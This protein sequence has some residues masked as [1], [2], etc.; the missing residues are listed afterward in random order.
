M[1][2][3]FHCSK[4]PNRTASFLCT[5][6]NCSDNLICLTCVQSHTNHHSS[7]FLILNDT[8]IDEESLFHIVKKNQ[9][10]IHDKL[11]EIIKYNEN[12]ISTKISEIESIF[13]ILIKETI[14]AIT[15]FKYEVISKF[16]KDYYQESKIDIDLLN[17]LHQNLNQV[18]LEQEEDLFNVMN[19]IQLLE[20]D[21]LPLASKEINEIQ[22]IDA[23]HMIW[24]TFKINPQFS[25]N[26][27]GDLPEYC[28]RSNFFGEFIKFSRD[29]S[30][31]Y[32]TSFEKPLHQLNNSLIV[33]SP[34]RLEADVPH[35]FNNIIIEDGGKLSIDPWDGIKGGHLIL[36]CK[37][38]QIKPYGMIDVSNLGYLGGIPCDNTRPNVAYA[39]ES[40]EKK[41]KKTKQINNGGGG[42]GSQNN[43]YGSCGGGGGGY[44]TAGD[45]S[46][47]NIYDN[48]IKEGGAGGE[49]YGDD[50]MS[51]IYMGSGGG[52]G[53]PYHNG[54]IKAKG[55]NGGGIVIIIAEEFKNEGKV[56]ANG[57]DGEDAIEKSSGSGGGGGSG[58]SIYIVTDKI[59]EKGILSVIG[60]KG[61][62][63][64]KA[65]FGPWFLSSDGGKGGVGRIKI[66]DSLKNGKKI[67][68]FRT[69]NNFEFVQQLL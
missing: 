29:L 32:E 31:L 55:G 34:L 13:N 42:G 6:P 28:H 18:N 51:M 52:A 41:G 9:K 16:K 23:N 65:R 3:P 17:K 40:Y 54:G 14:N 2:P 57:G 44:G 35:I 50:E 66:L 68:I 61:G 11:S 7:R 45:N 36:I 58:G 49:T 64:G 12:A 59:I 19:K 30:I 67:N 4:H 38:L 53:A 26:F 37:S 15:Q 56:C 8:F 25:S 69:Q 5:Y 20:D 43:G 60:G 46:E 24:E 1:T 10:D 21:Y 22:P 48:I 63:K 47:P 33:S 62:D 39:G 27:L